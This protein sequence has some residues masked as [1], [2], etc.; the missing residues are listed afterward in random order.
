MMTDDHGFRRLVDPSERGAVRVHHRLSA[1]PGERAQLAKWLGVPAVLSLEST[2]FT[3]R[4]NSDT[5]VVTGT[6]SAELELNCSVS[7][8]PFAQTLDGSLTGSF[9]KPSARRAPASDEIVLDPDGE[10]EP[11]EWE[12]QGIDLGRLVAEELSLAVPP[13]PRKPGAALDPEVLGAADAKL[14]P[15]AVLGKLKEPGPTDN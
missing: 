1:E 3:E 7:L 5:V 9:R 8:E 2:V 10:D 4:K 15:F 6:Y 14:N 11:D 12:P 13:Y